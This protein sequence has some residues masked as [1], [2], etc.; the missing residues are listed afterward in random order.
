MTVV[1][2]TQYIAIVVTEK[3]L[4]ILILIIFLINC[5]RKTVGLPKSGETKRGEIKKRDLFSLTVSD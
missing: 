5:L 4:A 1:I 2:Q 3:L